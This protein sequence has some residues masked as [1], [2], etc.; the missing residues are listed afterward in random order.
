MRYRDGRCFEM[1]DPKISE[2]RGT[3]ILTFVDAMNPCWSGVL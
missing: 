2:L 1:V 3:I